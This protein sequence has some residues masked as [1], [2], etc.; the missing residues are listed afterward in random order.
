MRR[1]VIILLLFLPS[2]GTGAAELR[3]V[4]DVDRILSETDHRGLVVLNL[5]A[6]WCAPCV[7]EM[8]DLRDLDE[9]FDDDEAVFIGLSLDDAIPGD[10]ELIR[11]K[12]A[13]FLDRKGIEYLNLYW[14]GSA[15]PIFRKFDLDGEIPVT[16]VF[17]ESGREVYRRQG[18]I[19][20][21]ELRK[22]I[23]DESN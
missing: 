10:R 23:E 6:T 5:W 1:T 13:A 18:V 21:E 22:R 3:I 19:D 14:I 12:V 11:K 2:L 7:A 15:D 8:E 20:P 9:M 4:Q 17:D 16:V